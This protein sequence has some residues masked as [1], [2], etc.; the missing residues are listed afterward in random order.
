MAVV[1]YQT[2]GERQ[3]EVDAEMGRVEQ[4]LS[5]LE[6]QLTK[7]GDRLTYVR[8]SE[9]PSIREESEKET[10][11]SVPLVEALRAIRKKI[12]NYRQMTEMILDQLEI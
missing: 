9:P 7:L 3:R 4:E 12:C 8:R 5:L 2:K 6:M 10:G 11:S 1:G